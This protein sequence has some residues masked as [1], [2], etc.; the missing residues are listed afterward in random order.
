MKNN[1]VLNSVNNMQLIRSLFYF[2]AFLALGMSAGII[3]PTLPFLSNNLRIDL[4]KISYIF[5]IRSIGNMLGSYTSGHLFEKIKGHILFSSAMLIMCAVLFIIPVSKNMYITIISFFFFG[6]AEGCGHTGGNTL[7]IWNLDNKADW[8]IN[9]LHSCF[10]LGAFLSPLLVGFMLDVYK[11]T[12]FSYLIISIITFIILIIIFILPSPINI[13]TLV[14]KGPTQDHYEKLLITKTKRYIQI[15]LIILIFV[16]VGIESS[17][18]SWI[19]TFIQRQN[20]L[21]LKFA[22]LMT[23]VFFA[24]ITIGR[25]LIIPVTLRFSY[26]KIFGIS[27]FSAFL[28]IVIFYFKSRIPFFLCLS[29]GGFGLSVASLFPTIFS[30]AEK[31]LKITGKTTARL[32]IGATMGSMLFPWLIGQFIELVNSNVLPFLIGI[33]LFISLVCY[34]LL[35]RIIKKLV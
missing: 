23:S 16:A 11:G 13:N 14:K 6:F 30:L 12:I 27:L 29:V 2:I 28:F 1:I 22:A 34:L 9:I 18:G 7:L 31:Y 3:G 32:L 24:T 33:T 5:I 20:L 19:Y 4:S 15:L 26:I 10:G 25:L 17:F 8:N 35:V 21:N